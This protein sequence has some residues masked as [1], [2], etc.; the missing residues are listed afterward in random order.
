[1]RVGEIMGVPQAVLAPETTVAVGLAVMHECGAP[2][3]P[4]AN[5]EGILLG[6]VTL[7]DLPRLLAEAEARGSETVRQH[8][9]PHLVTATPEMDASRLAEMM[10][11]KA[12]KNIMVTEGKAFVR[13]LSLDQ[14]ARVG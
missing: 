2:S 3:L 12:M 14:A 1:M 4:V 8:L 11:Y 7:A 6:L 5:R 13:A 9:S 10:R